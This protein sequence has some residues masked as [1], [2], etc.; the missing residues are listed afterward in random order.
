MF[1]PSKH[2][3]QARSGPSHTGGGGFW[4]SPV[5]WL[6]WTLRTLRVDH[7]KK[8]QG[9]RTSGVRAKLLGLS[10]LLFLQTPDPEP[11]TANDTLKP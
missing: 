8:Q 6:K 2:H 4:D 10:L 9:E 1:L 5:L 11:S 3:T 7:A